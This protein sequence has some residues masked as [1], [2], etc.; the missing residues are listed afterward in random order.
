VIEYWQF[1]AWNDSDQSLSIGDHQ[2]DWCT[3]SL[4]YDPER[5]QIAQVT[6]YAHGKPIQ[7]NLESELV[8]HRLYGDILPIP[9]FY[10]NEGWGN[11][12]EYRGV[13]YGYSF[14]GFVDGSDCLAITDGL[15]SN[16]Q[17]CRYHD[18]TV[19]FYQDLSSGQ[20][21]HPVVYL[22]WGAHEFWP[23]GSGHVSMTICL[24]DLAEW[25]SIGWFL[26]TGTPPIV[27]VTKDSPK[28]GGDDSEKRYLTKSVPNLGEVE[29]ENMPSDE[30][31]LILRFNGR[32]GDYGKENDPP[33]GPALHESWRWPMG[34]PLRSRI[35]DSAFE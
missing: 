32:W 28:H 9:Y 35:P 17:D 8:D 23:T 16:N 19:R 27:C 33:P 4:Q 21:T 12:V 30:A 34:S 7:F 14:D 20:Y 11:Y 10:F 26:L 3:I 24:K 15:F 6:H 29:S 5:D 22:E 1:F 2:G 18:N 25:Y 31:K 13:N